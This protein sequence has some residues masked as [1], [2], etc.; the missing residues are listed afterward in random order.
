MKT[1]FKEEVERRFEEE[2]F[3]EE[4]SVEKIAEDNWHIFFRGVSKAVRVERGR[5][6]IFMFLSSRRIFHDCCW[7][8]SNHQELSLI[9]REWQEIDPE[10][11]FRAFVV[12]NKLT[13]CTQ[14][15]DVICF[16]FFFTNSTPFFFFFSFS[17]QINFPH[18]TCLFQ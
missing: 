13:S 3:G 9:V 1:L 12:R 4:D 7:A 17:F 11:E 14:Y 5:E 18:R 15:T 8:L 10:Y 2:K 16:V 6:A